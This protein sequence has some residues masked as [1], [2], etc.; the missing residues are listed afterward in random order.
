MSSTAPPPNPH[1]KEQTVAANQSKSPG[2]LRADEIA[3]KVQASCAHY[4][5]SGMRWAAEA[6]QLRGYV[7]SLCWEIDD[8]KDLPRAIVRANPE[9]EV[10]LSIL[11]AIAEFIPS[12]L[13]D[14]FGCVINGV[15]DS[16][17]D[18]RSDEERIEDFEL[19]R[20][21]LADSDARFQEAA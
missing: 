11:Q 7:R 3:Q 9:G 4:T 8:L 15:S 2:D 12:D 10:L 20:A 13:R 14:D 6:G 1:I 5:D 18:A 21:E 17:A 19:D 16:I